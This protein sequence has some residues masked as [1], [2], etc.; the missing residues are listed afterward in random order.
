MNRA[1]KGILHV[2]EEH[3]TTYQSVIYV[4]CKRSVQGSGDD[5]IIINFILLLLSEVVVLL[6]LVFSV[7]LR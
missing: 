5:I 3:A 2:V 4:L 6:S 7:F 1:G